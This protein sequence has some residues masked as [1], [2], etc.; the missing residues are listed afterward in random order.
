MDHDRTLLFAVFVH[1]FE[2]KVQ[3]HLKIKLNG[4]ALPGTSQRILQVEVDLRAVKGAVAL[5]DAIR[6]VQLFQ[7]LYKTLGCLLPI[8]VAA[9][10]VLRSGGKLNRIAESELM[11]HLVDQVDNAHDLVRD[12]V[13]A[14]KDMRIVLGE[15]PYP[16]KAV[17]RTAHLMPVY[18]SKLAD[19]HRQFAVA[20]RSV[21]IDH[22]AAG[23]VHRLD[24]VRVLVNHGCVHVVLIVIPV[25][26]C[27]PQLAVHN[28]RRGNLHIA[29]LKV[30]T[31]PI[32]NQGIFQRHA[33][34]QKERETRC[35]VAEHKKT[36]FLT[37]FTVIPLFGLFQHHKVGF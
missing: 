33:L 18:Q 9:H 31:A 29:V 14:H 13:A 27:L 11:V 37:N 36:H 10:A 35:L 4:S 28:H 16:K 17:Q 8:R 22:H 32:V 26:A 20:V 6:Q 23:T 12:L 30:Q 24:A 25:S 7:C 21:L 19:P 15:A 1:I 3:R 2:C 5:V 34:W